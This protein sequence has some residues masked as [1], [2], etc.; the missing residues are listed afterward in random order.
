MKTNYGLF[1]EHEDNGNLLI[2]FASE[3]YDA[4]E[5]R[6]EVTIFYKKGQVVGY[7]IS[8]FIRYAKIK[9][10]GIVFLP[11]KPLIDVINSVLENNGLNTLE[12]KKQSGYVVKQDGDI[13]KVYALE[14]TFLRDKTISK[15]R[16]CT[17]YD[18]YITS[19]NEN[20]LIVIDEDIKEGTDFF[21]MEEK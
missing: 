11:S 9:Y 16:F 1:N 13:K 18:L 6:D 14:G 8:N 7:A 10:S 2:L 19:E 20:D 17:Y 12:F 15:G 5:N 21:Q 3:D 4:E